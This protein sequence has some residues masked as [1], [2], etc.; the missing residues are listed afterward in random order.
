MP[1]LASALFAC[2]LRADPGSGTIGVDRSWQV[3]ADPAIVERLDAEQLGRL[4]VHLCGHL[5]R[6]HAARSE[7]LGVPVGGDRARWNR[8]ADAEIND[9]LAVDDCIPEVASD[10]PMDL[11]CEAGLLAERYYADAGDGPRRWDCGSGADGCPR[12]GDGRG[13]IGR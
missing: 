7:R 11:G 9:D 4:L 5:I 12:P 8:C 13:S 1:Y 3:R 6:D 2:S 10:L